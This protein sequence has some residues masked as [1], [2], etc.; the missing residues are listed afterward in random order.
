MA[1][2]VAEAIEGPGS[3]RRRS[4]GSAPLAIEATG[5]VK[6]FGATRAVA[7]VDL[8]VAA[9]TVYGLLGPNG[10]GKPVTGL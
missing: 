3:G 6:H 9:G 1:V 7:G 4:P 2:S 5:L 10:A 8:A